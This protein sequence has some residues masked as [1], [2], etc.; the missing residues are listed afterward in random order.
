L[1]SFIAMAQDKPNSNA[2]ADSVIKQVPTEIIGHTQYNYAINGKKQ[3]SEDVKARLYAYAPSK[4]E[5]LKSS[6]QTSLYG[7]SV[8]GFG[9]SGVGATLQYIDGS[10]PHH[11]LNGA[12]VL[13]GAATAFV[14][15]SIFHGLSAK[16]HSHKALAL[17][18][19]Q[20][21]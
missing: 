9:I 7:L 16:H 3:T 2:K 14:I 5:L 19:Q 12:Y 10:G 15:S 18:N 8:I 21:Q 13:T 6:R 11:N 20:Y 4:A 1:A 17:Y